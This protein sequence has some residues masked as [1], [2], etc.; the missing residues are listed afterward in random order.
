MAH[1][2]EVRGTTVVGI[3]SAHGKALPVGSWKWRRASHGDAEQAGIS[4]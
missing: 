2:S 3:C 1:D 4:L